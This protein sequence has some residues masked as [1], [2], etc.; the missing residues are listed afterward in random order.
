MLNPNMLNCSSLF[1][2]LFFLNTYN[3]TKQLY[4]NPKGDFNCKLKEIVA[5]KYCL[6]HHR[7]ETLLGTALKGNSFSFGYTKYWG[8]I[9]HFSIQLKWSNF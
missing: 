2:V 7:E 8:F 5:T 1:L 3:N 4:R 9:N 6:R